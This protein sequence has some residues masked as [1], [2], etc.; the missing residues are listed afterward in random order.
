MLGLLCL[1]AVLADVVQVV[2]AD[3]NGVGH[4]PG[5]DDEALAE[6]EARGGAVKGGRGGEVGPERSR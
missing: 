3:D 6:I 4:L 1:P 5:R 2:T